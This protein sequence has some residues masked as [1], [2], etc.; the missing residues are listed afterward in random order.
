M[1][2]A[3]SSAGLGLY[4][5]A[6]ENCRAKQ[7][8]GA[9]DLDARAREH[10]HGLASALRA[11]GGRGGLAGGVIGQY[12]LFGAYDEDKDGGVI[13]LARAVAVRG[14]AAGATSR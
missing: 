14:L 6:N 9:G 11:R 3:P 1:E 13:W 7:G 2:E 5:Y 8:A 12:L 10:G 4:K